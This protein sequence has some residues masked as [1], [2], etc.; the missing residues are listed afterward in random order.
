M[1]QVSKENSYVD[2]MVYF[3][4]PYSAQDIINNFLHY[5]LFTERKQERHVTKTVQYKVNIFTYRYKSNRWH[6]R[7]NHS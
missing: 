5:I 2:G 1:Q 4:D 7:L 3:N 6:L